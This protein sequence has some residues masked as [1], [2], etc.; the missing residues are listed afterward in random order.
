[1]LIDIRI[2]RHRCAELS[3]G[4]ADGP[5]ILEERAPCGL[6]VAS[7][8]SRRGYETVLGQSCHA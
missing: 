2:E 7:G 5:P 4:L 8:R 6:Q 3:R 1:M